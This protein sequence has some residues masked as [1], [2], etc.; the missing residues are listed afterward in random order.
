MQGK[1][2]V[3]EPPP[4]PKGEIVPDKL[5]KILS[6][7]SEYS[8]NPEVKAKLAELSDLIEERNNFVIEKYGQPLYSEDGR[9]SIEDARQEL[10]D[11]LQY[12]CKIK[13][14]KHK[15]PEE[16]QEFL[17]LVKTGLVVINYIFSYFGEIRTGTPNPT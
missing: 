9:N 3:P 11:L 12:V 17:K 4:V 6:Q 1:K 8:A 14:Q 5:I 16:I 7:M 10:G 13:M 15:D 2:S